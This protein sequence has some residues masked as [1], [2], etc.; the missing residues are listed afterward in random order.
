GLA[1]DPDFAH[2][3]FVYMLYTV[4]PDSNG[5]DAET[6][7]FGR[8][9]RYRVKADDPNRIDESSRT[10]LVGRT[11]RDGFVS[12]TLSHGVGALQ[13]GNDGS[14]MVSCGDGAHYD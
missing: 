13:W 2:N 1:V 5:V 9:S 3:G 14:L 6:V 12:A 4:D 11:W 7:S 10:V 8:V